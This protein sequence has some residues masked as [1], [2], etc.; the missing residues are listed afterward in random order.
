MKK[1]LGVV[2]ALVVFMG[3]S[4]AAQAQYAVTN[5]VIFVRLGYIPAYTVSFDEQDWDDLEFSGFA[6]NGEYN[7]N[8]GQFWIGIGLEYQYVVDED[9][10]DGT[11][12][13]TA[14]F[15]LPQVNAKFVTGGG[16]YIGAGFSGKYLI[17]QDYGNSD[18][19]A[20]K[21]IDL[22]GN[23]IIGFFTP[24]TEGVYFD[25]EGRFGYNLT[26]NQF[27]EWE[28]SSD[29]IGMDSAYDIAIYVGVG[30]RA[31]STGL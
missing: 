4:V 24:I 1:L 22:W 20:K 5:D 15:L 14:Q 26:N 3:V 31:L 28:D 27:S 11:E 12:D 25:V 17:S 21:K 8:M 6:A 7:V 13:Y 16:L 9:A 19:E 23:I 29:K 10:Q 30:F 2:A 18:Y